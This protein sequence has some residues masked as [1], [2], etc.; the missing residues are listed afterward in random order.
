MIQS[1]DTHEFVLISKEA[2]NGCP[3]FVVTVADKSMEPLLFEGDI[4]L[5]KAQPIVKHGELG[6]F[7]I[8]GKMCVKRMYLAGQSH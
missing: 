6:V 5:A 4:M 8:D 2:G 3:D 1:T 7:T